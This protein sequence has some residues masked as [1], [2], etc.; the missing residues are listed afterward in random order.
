M[1]RSSTAVLRAAAILDFIAEHPG[2]SFTMVE[3]VRALK[4]SHS[5]CHSLVS[6][7]VDVGY[8]HRTAQ[9]SYAL[10]PRLAA[11]ARVSRDHASLLEIA[12]PE[13][14]D[15]ATKH[16]LVCSVLMR[17]GNF[18]V[19]RERS[20]SARHIGYTSQI[21]MPLRLRAP[22]AAAFFI[23][24]PGHAEEW[25][26]LNADLNL[27]A[28]RT[29]VQNGIDFLRAHGFLALLTNPNAPP[30]ETTPLDK[31]FDGEVDKLS[32]MTA[33][34]IDP[35]A[36]YDVSSIVAP[37]FNAESEVEFVLSLIGY[38]EPILGSEIF[39]LGDEVKSAS[40]RISSAVLDTSRRSK[41]LHV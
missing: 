5:T 14:R 36:R 32:V 18:S 27:D 3:L 21:G 23:T 8:L 38:E 17:E 4:L 1:A 2:Q 40:I 15:L 31:L 10:G 30:A 11:I 25:L 34:A 13:L 26:A 35:S 9:K 33:L 7:L 19:V 41:F 29:V 28:E 12:K 39:V 16:D 22:L 24:S 6:A 37:V 20:T